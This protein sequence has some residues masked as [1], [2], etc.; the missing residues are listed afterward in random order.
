MVHRHVWLVVAKKR[1]D[2]GHVVGKIIAQQQV[3]GVD[4][5]AVLTGA[6]SHQLLRLPIHASIG[7]ATW[8]AS[9]HG[10]RLLPL[11]VGSSSRA[12]PR[13]ELL[14]RHIQPGGIIGGR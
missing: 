8:A 1:F 2:V 3:E 7:L 13:G 11:Q 6:A 4:V 14:D 9:S 5:G 12:T 10:Q